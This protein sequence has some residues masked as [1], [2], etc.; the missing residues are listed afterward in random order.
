MS[1]D[2]ATRASLFGCASQALRIGAWSYIGHWSLVIRS[3]GPALR[4]R[5]LL[6]FIGRHIHEELIQE[7]HEEPLLD[8]AVIG[9]DFLAHGHDHEWM[10][11]GGGDGRQAG[12]TEVDDFPGCSGPLLFWHFGLQP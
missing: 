4:L 2:Q 7:I 11:S 12:L 1:N 6:P 8:M 9:N 5:C 10:A 3:K